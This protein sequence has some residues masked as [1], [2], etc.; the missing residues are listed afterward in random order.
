MLANWQRTLAALLF[1]VFV[2]STGIALAVEGESPSDIVQSAASDETVI[3]EW[4]IER[5]GE[6]LPLDTLFRDEAGKEVTLGEVVDKPTLILPIYF[7]CP[8]SCSRNLANM[9]VAM[10][11]MS[12]EPGRDY[13]P[14]ALSFSDTETPENALR[15][16]RNYLKLV[17]DQFPDAEWKFLTGSAESIHAVTE[18]LGFRFKKV[19]DGTFLH[20]SVVIGVA[21]D[22][23]IVRY[24][25][26]SFV[27]GDMDLA[28]AS[29]RDG[30]P[31][32]SIKRFLEFCLSYDPDQ[33]KPLFTYVKIGVV[34]F[35]ATLVALIFRFS[36]K[37]G[38]GAGRNGT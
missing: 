33:N 22:G 3:D 35:F 10:N 38:R 5:T 26:G 20:P 6:F 11:Q 7:Y 30:T 16:K 13:R 19:D 15:A 28:V 31:T 21:A 18:A 9:A 32:L 25:Y 1:V 2:Q 14:I 29:A 8:S 23:K 27:P 36:R 17:Y 34:I 4:V 24:V 37:R 12:F